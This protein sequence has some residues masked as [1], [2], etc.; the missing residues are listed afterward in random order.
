MHERD[1]CKL[2]CGQDR[3]CGLFLQ[4]ARHPE[5]S[6]GMPRRAAHEMFVR[7]I[8]FH[9]ACV[10]ITAYGCSVSCVY[11]SLQNTTF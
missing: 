1:S 8:A 6:H 7:G 10:L 2:F 11:W 4:G 9:G 5:K 3:L